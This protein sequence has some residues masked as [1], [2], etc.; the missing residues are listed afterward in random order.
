MGGERKAG[1]TKMERETQWLGQIGKGRAYADGSWVWA[2]D[3][4]VGVGWLWARRMV[5]WVVLTLT[6]SSDR[7]FKT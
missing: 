3:E 6:S 2:S 1:A 5:G 4:K 7:A